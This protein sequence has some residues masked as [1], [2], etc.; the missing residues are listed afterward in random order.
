MGNR[1]FKRGRVDKVPTPKNRAVGSD[2]VQYWS[3]DVF[4][5]EKRSEVMS[6]IRSRGTKPEL[7][8]ERIVTNTLPR[9]KIEC[10]P[11]S[12][13]G[14]PD[15]YVPSLR[16]AIFVEGCFWHSCPAH[17]RFP[18]SNNGYWEEKL[19]ANVAR[20]RRVA[21]ALRSQGIGV[22]H[23][24]EHSLRKSCLATTDARLSRRLRSRA[25]EVRSRT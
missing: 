20:D 19:R 24:W 17:G 13:A 22:W 5:P 9:W 2:I 15:I 14:R 1:S 16:L 12:I 4:T 25:A 3:M 7:A 21:R 18:K 6:A 11:A 8:V 23:V 10:H